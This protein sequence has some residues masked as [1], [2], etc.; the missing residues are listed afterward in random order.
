LEKA[1]QRLNSR[2]Q[3][4]ASGDL[5][6]LASDTRLTQEMR[7]GNEAAF[8]VAYRRHGGALL[9][10]CRQILS[11]PEEAEEALQHSLADA[12]TTLQRPD[13]PAPE[14][15][16]PW[17]YAIA[18]HRCLSMLRS[19]RPG[20]VP[21]TDTSVTGDLVDEIGR[22]AEL[23]ALLSD[24]H[25]L[26]EEQRSALVLSELAGLSHAEIAD[27]LQR[28]QPGV[29]ALVFQARKT[30]CDWREAREAPCSDIRVQLCVL[31]G[32]ALRRR[33]LKRHLQTCASC[34]EF[35]AELQTRRRPRLKLER[36]P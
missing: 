1:A 16:K 17:L 7:H 14:L 20:M 13:R 10:L 12:W 34:R 19:R 11:S 27:V 35:H 5:L 36:L 29:K 2:R 26:P 25:D 6:A 22:R 23:R 32:G 9:T 18:R 31:R 21:L 28:R 8:E 15:L 24:V 3:V 4:R 30:L 33:S